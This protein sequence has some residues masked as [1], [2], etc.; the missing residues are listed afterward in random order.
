LERLFSFIRAVLHRLNYQA[1]ATGLLAAGVVIL[2]AAGLTDRWLRIE[3]ARRQIYLNSLEKSLESVESA[4]SRIQDLAELKSH[5]LEIFKTGMAN[6]AQ[7]KKALYESGLSL[8]EEKRLLENQWNIMTTYLVID[9]P[10]QRII[11]MRG[12]QPLE[13]YPFSYI[14]IKAFGNLTDPL[15]KTVRITSKE[16]FAN[17]ERGE[18]REV[19]G[20]LEW[21]P[22]QIGTSVRS[23]A[24][25]EFVIFT[26][27]RLILHGPAIK[28]EDHE[29]FPHYCIG[30]S[31]EAARA[32]YRHSFIGTKIVV[33]RPEELI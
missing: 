14:P 31:R 9:I 27:S 23:N 21:T 30:L 1:P 10:L 32:L 3:L 28:P 6:L 8:Q 5:D 26:N 7:S 4:R 11:L 16:R 15:P 25:G 24:L 33:I 12:D 18:A 13:S 22:P 20:R 17:P 19:N 29:Q 2:A